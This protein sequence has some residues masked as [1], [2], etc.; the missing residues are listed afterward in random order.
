MPIIGVPRC[1]EKPFCA[2]AKFPLSVKKKIR[3]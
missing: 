2:P 1:L 3:I